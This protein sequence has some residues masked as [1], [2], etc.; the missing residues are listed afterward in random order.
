MVTLLDNYEAG[1]EMKMRMI[2]T[3]DNDE[4]KEGQREEIL[5]QVLELRFKKGKPCLTWAKHLKKELFKALTACKAEKVYTENSTHTVHLL[6]RLGTLKF[7]MNSTFTKL[8][9]K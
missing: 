2:I 9:K 3:D 5:I 4:Q 7:N 8:N 6:G 1:K